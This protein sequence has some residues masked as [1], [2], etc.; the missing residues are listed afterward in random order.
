MEKAADLERLLQ[1]SS[2]LATFDD[3]EQNG[4]ANEDQE[5]SPTEAICWFVGGEAPKP[6]V[7]AGAQEGKAGVAICCVINIGGPLLLRRS[8][9]SKRRLLAPHPLDASDQPCNNKKMHDEIRVQGKVSLPVWSSWL[10][11][12]QP[13]GRPKAEKEVGPSVGVLVFEYCFV[14]GGRDALPLLG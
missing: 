8:L 12:R 9:A 3:Q 14:A 10:E 4:A 7:A 6:A 2:H 5:V 11:S 13:W 1:P